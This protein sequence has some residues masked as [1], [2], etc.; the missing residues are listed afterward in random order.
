M[1]PRVFDPGGDFLRIDP[2]APARGGAE[3]PQT[4]LFLGR[5]EVRKGAGA[6]VCG[7]ETALL[8]SLEGKRGIVRAKPPLPAL[9]RP[10]CNRLNAVKT[11][12]SASATS[13]TIANVSSRLIR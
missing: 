3:R 11:M 9:H 7:E 2:Y 4:I 12:K 13:T 1:T 10:S 8:E 6:Y 5:L